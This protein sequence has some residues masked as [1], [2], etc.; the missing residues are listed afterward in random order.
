[1]K[2]KQRF[3]TDRTIL[4]LLA[5]L[6]AFPPI[7]TDLYLPAMPHMVQLLNT[8]QNLINLTL[9]IFFLFFSL[10]ILLWGPISEKYGRKPILLIGLVIYSLA[11]IG[12]ALSASVYQLIAARIL[13]ALGGGAA[14]AVATAMVKDMYSGRQREKVLAVVMAMVIVAPVVAPLLG[15]A[16]LKVA[17][18]RTVF[19]ILGGI[20]ILVFGLALLLDE[21]LDEKYTGSLAGSLF[22][23]GVVMKNPG[24][25]VLLGI[26][27]L[28]PL[29]MMAYVASSSFIYIRGF[30]LSEQSFSYFFAF[31]ALG[32]ICGPLLYIKISRWINARNLITLCFR[33]NSALRSVPDRGREPVALFLR[34]IHGRGDHV[35]EH[36]PAAD[37]QPDA[38]STKKGRRLGFV[39]D[40]LHRHAHGQHRNV[41]HL[42]AIRQ[43]DP[44]SGDDAS[45]DRGGLRQPVAVGQEQTLYSADGLIRTPGWS[46]RAR[47]V[48]LR[49]ASQKWQ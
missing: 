9:S 25:S 11:G 40:Q 37:G 4:I 8:S 34:R 27:S 30:G 32:S 18:W 7:S 45:H 48:R 15:A 47:F 20:G 22:R 2:T 19:W 5:L 28:A 16:I 14:V 36:D 10:S 17:S 13:Q 46:G 31:N 12:C 23:L 26:F 35:N 38:S 49:P 42:A 24:F 1:M 41:P 43:S 33:Y 6:S 39:A 3:Y 21:T 44:L 29:P